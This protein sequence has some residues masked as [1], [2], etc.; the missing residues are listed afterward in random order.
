[1]IF[2]GI[3]VSKKKLDVAV[4]LD[5]ST[6]KKR[7]KKLPNTPEGYQELV[8][9][10]QKHT[11]VELSQLQ[12]IM[13]ATGPYHED[14]ALALHQAGL[15]VSV[16]NPKALKDFAKGLGIK[17]KND[18]MDALTI[19][20]YGYLAQPRRWQ[21]D[22]PEFRQLGGLLKR[23]E[24]LE[25]DLQREQNRREKA[26]VGHASAEVLDSLSRTI[27]FLEQEKQHLIHSIDAHIDRHPHLQQDRER[28]QSIPGIGRVL[29][30]LMV[31]LLQHGQRF[32]S[33]A[34]L[35][36]YLG[37]IPTEHQSG[38]SVRKPPRLSKLGPARVRAKLYMAAIVATQHNPDVQAL[39]QRLLK[40]GKCKMAALGA[41]M[42]KLAHI[43][44]GVIK[45]QTPYQP[46]IT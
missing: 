3:D 31:L 18:A 33:A 44:F 36:S 8:R 22:P 38:S 39:Y 12:A 24:A 7:Q 20:R 29:S 26:Q 4:L 34:Q 19:A 40:R 46:Q 35:A 15:G 23:L 21:P 2:I 30:A 27:G 16:I 37:L 17:A 41:A 28:L 11:G 13:E 45:N 42:R 43:C 10:C 25:C 5:P 14:V 1:M 9:W 6:L 32:A